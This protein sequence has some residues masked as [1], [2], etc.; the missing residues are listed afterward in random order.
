MP[1]RFA[2]PAAAVLTGLI[3]AA[4]SAAA[5]SATPPGSGSPSAPPSVGGIGHPTGATELVLRMDTGGGFVPME[6]FAAHVPQFTLYGDGT[7]VWVSSASPVNP[8]NGPS[9]GQPIRTGRLGEDQVQA[10]L[11]FALG[12]GGLG[13]ARDS[14]SADGI[15][16]APSTTFTI[17]A[18]GCTRTVS[19]YALGMGMPGPDEAIRARFSKLAAR[20][21]AYDANGTAGAPY[22]AKGY[23]GVLTEATGVQVVPRAWPWP[24]IKPADFKL[25][26]NPSGFGRPQKVLTPEEVA[27]F[28]V[29]GYTNGITGGLFF[30]GP[31]GMTYSFALRPLLPDET[32]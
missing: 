31:D 6:F 7:V 29:A 10:L 18:D 22:V 21:A 14:Y 26:L 25:P 13:I 2:L 9:T 16:D 17:S 28:G 24:S 32:S 27:V 1:N 20:L 30:K 11:A 12:E 15:A 4:C 23:R 8:G 5:P 3:V 19:I